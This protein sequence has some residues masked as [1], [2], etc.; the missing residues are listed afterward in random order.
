M[1]ST[2]TWKFLVALSC[3]ITQFVG[4]AHATET[5]PERVVALVG[6]IPAGAA[7][8][9]M[10]LSEAGRPLHEEQPSAEPFGLPT[11]KLLDGPILSRWLELEEQLRKEDEILASCDENMSS[12]PRAARLFLAF[13]S[14]ASAN[15]G[16]RRIGILN[17]EINFAIRPTSDLSQWGVPDRWSAP[18]ETLS[19]ARGD[20]EDYAI[21]KYVALTIAGLPREDVKLVLVREDLS[22][23]DH[24]L[25]AARLDDQWIILD[26]RRLTLARDISF[27]A[28]TPL[29][30][31]DHA[32]V[33][34]FL[35]N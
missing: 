8:A 23:Q 29:F 20:C 34:R 2:R 24:A 28:T 17:R 9:P 35:H 19:T 27:R 7:E 1:L 18:L 22:N 16:R 5:R 25:V 32:G 33:R 31:L 6:K 3:A 13:I 15:R 21:A 10:P 26:N 30:V 11:E 12:C 4:P 14:E